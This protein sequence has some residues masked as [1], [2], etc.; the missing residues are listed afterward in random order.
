MN[1]MSYRI[2]LIFLVL[3]AMIFGAAYYVYTANQESSVPDGTLVQR[4]EQAV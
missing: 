1:R 2:W 4:M 3:A